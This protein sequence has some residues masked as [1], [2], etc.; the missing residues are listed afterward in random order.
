MF[1]S[2][3]IIRRID[4]QGRISIPQSLRKKFRF[5]EDSP[6]ELGENEESI[7]LRKYSEVGE[8]ADS[9]KSIIESFCVVTDLPVI[10]CSPDMVIISCM[11]ENISEKTISDELYEIIKK[12]VE[13]T[14]S[15]P[16]LKDGSV[17]AEEIVIIYSMNRAPVGALVIPECGKEITQSQIECL[18]LCAKAI[19]KMVG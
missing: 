14:H 2:T 4:N 10:L 13:R 7:V 1:K 15:V 17:R 5:D 16:V 19:G 6:I 12:K 18:K 8:F 9:S 3:G 11:T